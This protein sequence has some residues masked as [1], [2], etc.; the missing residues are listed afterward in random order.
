MN[1]ENNNCFGGEDILLLT[2]GKWQM[3]NGNGSHVNWTVQIYSG[4][5]SVLPSKNSKWNCTQA[6]SVEPQPL[7]LNDGILMRLFFSIPA[8]T[9]WFLL[10]WG[11]TPRQIKSER[12]N[13]LV[14]FQIVRVQRRMVTCNVEQWLVENIFLCCYLVHYSNLLFLVT[15]ITCIWLCYFSVF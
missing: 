3:A 5:I 12:I 4:N 11:Y 8:Y 2:D 15:H 6:F 1:R 9:Q 13:R 10:A 7:L 14:T